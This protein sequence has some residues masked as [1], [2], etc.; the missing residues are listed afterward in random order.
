MQLWRT[1]TRLPWPVA[2]QL[3]LANA[4][5]AKNAWRISAVAEPA[6]CHYYPF[7]V[8][9]HTNPLTG[10]LTLTASS[11]EISR[12][13]AHPVTVRQCSL[14]PQTLM[15]ARATLENSP[16]SMLKVEGIRAI[17]IASQIIAVS[18]S[19][20]SKCMPHIEKLNRQ[21]LYQVSQNL[22]DPLHLMITQHLQAKNVWTI[23]GIY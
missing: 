21:S 1:T 2:Q 5:P 18:F 9:S 16:S 7:Q 17:W 13:M 12:G 20:Q 10:W 22:V 23:Y 14:A 4:V 6:P 11:S 15:W 8:A 19:V 3:G